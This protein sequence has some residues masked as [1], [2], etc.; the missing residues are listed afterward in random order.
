[1]SKIIFDGD[2]TLEKPT[3]FTTVREEFLARLSAA[4]VMC[5][6]R[7]RAGGEYR[8]IIERKQ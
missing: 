3:R 8:I 2:V 5:G 6:T 1:M 7:L 4:L